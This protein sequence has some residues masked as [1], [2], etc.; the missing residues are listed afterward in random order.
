MTRVAVISGVA[1]IVVTALVAAEATTGI[2]DEWNEAMIDT[3]VGWLV[4]VAQVVSWIGSTTVAIALAVVIAAA[5]VVGRRLRHAAAFAGVAIAAFVVSQ[6]V[7]TL[8]DRERP[9]D[10]IELET[11]GSYPSASVMVSATAIV[12]GA[13]LVAGLEWPRWRTSMVAAASVFVIVMA[14][15]RTYLRAHWLTDVVGGAAGGL[16][17]VAV[18]IVVLG[19]A[20][21]RSAPDSRPTVST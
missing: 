14:W 13:A 17:I 20:L 11:S 4:D 16:A 15:S 7:K 9:P 10:P 2:D 3:E 19:I 12:L 1:F 18:G 8:L 21:R 5:F 6:L